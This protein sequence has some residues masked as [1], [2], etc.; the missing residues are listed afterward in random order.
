M[1]FE[2]FALNSGITDPM[3]THMHEYC[4]NEQSVDDIVHKKLM[5]AF[6]YYLI[7]EENKEENRENFFG[8]RPIFRIVFFTRC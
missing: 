7:N 2:E 1:S 5:Q 4:R 8:S 6:Y 3:V